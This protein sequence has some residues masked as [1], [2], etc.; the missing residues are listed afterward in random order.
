MSEKQDEEEENAPS[1]DSMISFYTADTHEPGSQQNPID[2]DWFFIRLD[3]P[4]LAINVLW[5]TRSN[6]IDDWRATHPT[7]N[8]ES[9]L[10][11]SYCRIC[12]LHGHLPDGCLRRGPFICTYCREIGHET[13]DC[14]ELRHDEA[15]YHPELQFCLICSQPGHLLNQCFA[16]LHPLQ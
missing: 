6:P 8:L 9:S 7:N 4:H 16:L 11:L 5:R 15:R 12:G 2:I 13:T 1:E 10:P 3:I 14:V